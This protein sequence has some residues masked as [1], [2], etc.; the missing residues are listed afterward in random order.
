MSDLVKLNPQKN[1][2]SLVV[3]LFS[4]AWLGLQK[5]R[6]QRVVYYTVYEFGQKV[7]NITF[8]WAIPLVVAYL[9]DVEAGVLKSNIEK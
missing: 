9:G 2:E 1:T 7:T 3:R 4:P 8:N 5:C 6:Q